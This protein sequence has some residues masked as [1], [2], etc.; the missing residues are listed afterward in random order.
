MGRKI[1][2]KIFKCQ[3]I[4]Y[5][6]GFK[7]WKTKEKYLGA[8]RDAAQV[9]NISKKSLAYFEDKLYLAKFGYQIYGTQTKRLKKGWTNERYP[10]KD[11]EHLN[12]RAVLRKDLEKRKET[13]FCL[14]FSPSFN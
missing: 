7:N 12:Q 10:V 8:F 11:K 1:H 6:I 3:G 13:R 9:G 14:H 4:F 2:Y 5:I